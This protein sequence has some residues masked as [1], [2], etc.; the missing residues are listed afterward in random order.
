MRHYLS[1]KAKKWPKDAFQQQQK[2]RLSVHPKYVNYQNSMICLQTGH[3]YKKNQFKSV[4]DF[5]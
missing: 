1:G 5:D 4:F 2:M 3:I